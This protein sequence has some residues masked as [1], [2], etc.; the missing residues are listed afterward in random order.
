[1]D[2]ALEK[3]KQWT[4]FS[5]RLQKLLAS[6]R[7]SLIDDYQALTADLARARSL[8][9]SRATIDQ[10][11]RAAVAG[12]NL[13]YGQIRQGRSGNTK[14][15]GTFARG[16]GKNVWALGLSAFILFGPAAATYCAVRLHP[17]LG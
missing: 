5:L 7:T 10:L 6:G 13:L 8:G 11:N 4:E 15:W 2:L 14:W 16:F 12:H 9:A 1:M 3:Q 17:T